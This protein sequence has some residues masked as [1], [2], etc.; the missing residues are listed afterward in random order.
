MKDVDR[1]FH[2]I[3]KVVSVVELYRGIAELDLHGVVARRA[4]R[5]ADV[6]VPTLSDRIDAG[7][8]AQAS[9]RLKLIANYG[10]GVV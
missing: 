10:A 9:D 4:M 8:I 1:R 5:E 7:L 2:A 6:I 3:P